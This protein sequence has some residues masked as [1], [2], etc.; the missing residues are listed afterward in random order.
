MENLGVNYNQTNGKHGERIE[1]TEKV[2]TLN[3]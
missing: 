3:S 2:V 1:D